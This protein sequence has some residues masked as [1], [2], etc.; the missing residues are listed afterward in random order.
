MKIVN[1][2]QHAATPIIDVK[3]LL[4]F[5][6]M[7]NR[8]EIQVVARELA[9]IADLSGAEG[10]LIGGVPFLMGPPETALAERGIAPLYAFSMRESAEETQADGTVIKKNRFKHLGFVGLLEEELREAVAGEASRVAG[11]LPRPLCLR[12][13]QRR[14]QDVP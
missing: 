5:N 12:G 14:G 3:E 9:A 1:L 10:A 4:T 13:L 6:R 8:A 7:P 2:T 11:N